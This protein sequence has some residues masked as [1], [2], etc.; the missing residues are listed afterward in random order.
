MITPVSNKRGEASSAPNICWRAKSR[1]A[2]RKH[3][4]ERGQRASARTD[5]YGERTQPGEHGAKGADGGATRQAQ[6]IRIGER[7]TQQHLH[8]RTRQRK[9]AADG[10]RSER[11]RQA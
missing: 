7:I 10:K 11:A 9:Q 5:V 3:Q 4:H 6:H 8:Q 2:E 1:R